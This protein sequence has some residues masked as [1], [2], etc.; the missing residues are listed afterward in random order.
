[1]NPMSRYN[2]NGNPA[3]VTK[4]NCIKR[5]AQKSTQKTKETT[6]KFKNKQKQSQQII[7][8]DIPAW[9]SSKKFNPDAW[10]EINTGKTAQV[11][12]Q[13][14]PTPK[15]K[16]RANQVPIVNLQAIELAKPQETDVKQ[17]AKP[18]QELPQKIVDAAQIET[19]PVENMDSP[20]NA[21]SSDIVLVY[22]NYLSGEIS[23]L[24]NGLLKYTNRVYTIPADNLSAGTLPKTNFLAFNLLVNPRQIDPTEL[25]RHLIGVEKKCSKKCVTVALDRSKTKKEL[26]N[27]Y[28]KNIHTSGFVKDGQFEKKY[29]IQQCSPD[30]EVSLITEKASLELTQKMGDIYQE[31][32]Q[33]KENKGLKLPINLNVN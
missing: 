3:T 8:T 28:E 6:Q 17:E 31:F 4:T 5:S 2:N 1:M 9:N 23:K 19:E 20:L 30:L 21:N 26:S 10:P 22:D 27:F 29:I 14:I 11:A 18:Q 13:L 7:K 16:P 12:H 32:V 24:K 25:N 33:A 15:E